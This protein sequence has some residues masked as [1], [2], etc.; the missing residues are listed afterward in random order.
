MVYLSYYDKN[1]PHYPSKVNP[2]NIGR[3]YLIGNIKG[4]AAAFALS[5]AASVL[6]FTFMLIFLEWKERRGAENDFGRSPLQG[7]R[8][9]NHRFTF[10]SA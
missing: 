2:Q 10:L 8:A 9:E 1:I 3:S 7:N 6:V 5:F 4:V